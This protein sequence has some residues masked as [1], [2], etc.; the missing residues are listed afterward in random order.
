MRAIAT[1]TA[2]P[3]ASGDGRRG[4]KITDAQ[5]TDLRTVLDS[6]LTPYLVA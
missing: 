5:K 2:A 4:G 3:S 6:Y 1:G